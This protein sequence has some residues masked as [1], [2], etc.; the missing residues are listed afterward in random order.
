MKKIFLTLLVAGLAGL[1]LVGGG[2]PRAEEEKE[3]PEEIMIHNKGYR[4]TLFEPVRFTHQVHNEDYGIDCSE[5]HHNYQGGENVWQEGDPV[6][7]CD[8]CHSPKM[9]QGDVPRLLFAYHFECRKCHKENDSG[10]IEC[11]EC[12][13]KQ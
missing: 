12:H 9:K 13:T 6:Q 7:K 2:P 4:R 3:A 11:K 10:P 8:V 5:C 1:I